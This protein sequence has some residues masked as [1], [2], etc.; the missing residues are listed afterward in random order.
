MRSFTELLCHGVCETG[1]L[2]YNTDYT[3]LFPK[4]LLAGYDVN[5][6]YY[7]VKIEESESEHRPPGIEF[8]ALA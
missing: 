6:G 3:F 1:T 5:K 4:Q 7:K 2:R 8:R